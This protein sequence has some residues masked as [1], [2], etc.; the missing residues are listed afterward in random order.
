MLAAVAFTTF[1]AID[2]DDLGTF[3]IGAAATY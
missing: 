1:V 2:Y 3:Q